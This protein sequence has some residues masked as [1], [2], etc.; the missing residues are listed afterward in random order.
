MTTRHA[1]V[2]GRAR[3]ALIEYAAAR[4]F[5]PDAC[6]V[7]VGQMGVAFPDPINHWVSFHVELF[8]HWIPKRA[9]AGFSTAGCYWGVEYR[10]CRLGESTTSARPLR[11][12]KCVGGSSGLAAT[13]VAID[14]LRAERVI[15]AGVPLTARAG[16]YNGAETWDEASK[17]WAA[18]EEQMPR[19]LGRVRSMSGRT[20]DALGA[21]TEEWINGCD[22]GEGDPAR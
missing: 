7:M 8:N 21:P 11:Y 17:Y 5:C 20:R 6:V 1:I 15:L 19:L 12:V 14:E 9:A 10:G 18:W 16:Q 13:L 2:V 4:A 22:P 3:D